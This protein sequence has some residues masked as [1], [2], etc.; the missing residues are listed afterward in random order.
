MEDLDTSGGGGGRSVDLRESQQKNPPWSIPLLVLSALN[1]VVILTYEIFIVCRSARISPS[2]RHL[3]LSQILLLGLL[4]GCCVGFAY[5]LEVSAATCIVIRFGTGFSY[6]LIFSSLLVKLVFLISLNTGVYLPAL[7]Q[8]L[9]LTFCVLVQLVVEAEWLSLVPDCQFSS[10]DHIF[11]IAYIIFLII[12]VGSLS[13][14][15]RKIKDNYREASYIALLL[16]LA[17]PLWLTWII[18]AFMLPDS[19]H[20]VCFGFGLLGT[21]MIT[22]VVMFLPKSRQMTAM[23]REGVFIED[24]DDEISHDRMETQYHQYR[25][26]KKSSPFSKRDSIHEG[27]GGGGAGGAYQNGGSYL[28]FHR[29]LGVIPPSSSPPSY[30]HAPAPWTDPPQYQGYNFPSHFYPEKLYQYWHYYYPRVPG[31]QYQRMSAADMIPNISTVYD[32]YR[33]KSK[34][35]KPSPR[36][37]VYNPQSYYYKY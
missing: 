27:G 3:F 33:S 25:Q 10:T 32:R 30:R 22:F 36:V 14:K 15:S 37:P 6:V 13:L 2:R 8:A 23:G 35:P 11:S 29:P 24:R 9:L 7:Y 31:M 28:G 21:C 16:L 26:M 4:S 17:V 34:S 20:N 18:A 5:G 12:F 19:F 1:V